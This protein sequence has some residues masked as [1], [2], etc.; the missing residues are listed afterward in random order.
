MDI[1][2]NIDMPNTSATSPSSL[3]AYSLNAKLPTLFPKSHSPI[4]IHSRGYI[5]PPL[6]S[7]GEA[8][9]LNIQRGRKTAQD[10]RDKI[11]YLSKE[12]RGLGTENKSLQCQV[13]FLETEDAALKRRLARRMG[14]RGVRKRMVGG[15][16]FRA[17]TGT[18]A[19]WLDGGYEKT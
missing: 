1:D 7:M 4:N 6:I 16:G 11:W 5:I 2:T 3:A 13:A 19:I 12:V 18:A 9:K 8:R 17:T 10:L 14:R 15:G